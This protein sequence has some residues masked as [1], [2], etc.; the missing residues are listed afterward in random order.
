M[1]I[2]DL[3]TRPCG[4]SNF[5]DLCSSL[6]NQGAALGGGHYQPQGDGGFGRPGGGHQ[7]LEILLKL[8]ADEGKRLENGGVSPCHCHNPLW[9]S[10]ISDVDL[11]S[12]LRNIR[13]QN[14][15]IAEFLVSMKF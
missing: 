10:T 4:L 14:T 8:S 7:G 2:A 5:P 13:L 1:V 9:T 11:G 15:Q 3:N 12:T 6:A